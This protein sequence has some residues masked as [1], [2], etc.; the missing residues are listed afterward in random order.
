MSLDLVTLDVL[1]VLVVTTAAGLMR[2]FAGVGSGMLMAP[3]FVVIFGPI[4]TVATIIIMEIAVTV[5]LWFGIRRQ[6]DWRL[7]G[8]MGLAAALFMP[9]GTWLLVSVDRAVLT[10]GIPGLVLISALVLAT[11]WRY[12]GRKYLPLSLGVGALSGT[13][14]A[15]TSL[16][17]PPVMVYLLAGQD[18][19]ST[20]RANLIAYF[21]VTLLALITWMLARGLIGWDS[22]QRAVGLL[23]PFAI[24]TAV[25]SRLFS[26]SH[27]TLY[28]KVALGLLVAAGSF[29]LLRP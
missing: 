9:L 16:G 13:L 19:A 26:K 1:T 28:R 22:L 24:G 12:H 2:G 15:S 21:A 7:V 11:G 18:R 27:E 29:G 14:M 8:S 3:F 5:Q 4:E 6:I 17:N 23:V 20:N 25:G 10:R